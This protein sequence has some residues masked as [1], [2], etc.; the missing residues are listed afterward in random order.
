M[1]LEMRIKSLIGLLLVVLV[2]ALPACTSSTASTPI[3]Q[4]PAT[5]LIPAYSINISFP[6]QL[7]LVTVKQ[8][9]SVILPVSVKSL[10][11]Q[12]INIKLVLVANIGQLPLFLKYSQPNDG[13]FVTLA[14]NASLDTQIT[15]TVSDDA[16]VGDYKIGIHGQLQEPVEDRSTETM[17]LDLV[18]IAK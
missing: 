8:G 4:L 12:P 6:S 15:I 9:D 3:M 10:V 5:K 14:P 16:Q 11:D 18:I 17:F 13:Q 7:S 1:R 2:V